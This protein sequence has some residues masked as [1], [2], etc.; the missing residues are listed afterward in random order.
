ME[1]EQRLWPF[2]AC[3][4]TIPASLILWGVGAAH[5]VHWFGLIVAMGTLAGSTVFGITL[6]VDYL[7][8]TYHENKSQRLLRLKAPASS[9]SR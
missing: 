4:V 8:D 6:S 5:H 9:G 2:V 3:I 1:P 7:I